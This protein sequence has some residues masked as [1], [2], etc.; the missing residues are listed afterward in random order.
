MTEQTERSCSRRGAAWDGWRSIASS[1]LALLLLL[2][3]GGSLPD[4]AAPAPNAA[5]PGSVDCIPLDA[6]P[7]GLFWDSK[8][9]AL[10]IADAAGNRILKWTEAG[11][12]VPF[13]ALPEAE[14]GAGLGQIAQSADGTL[15]VTRFGKGSTGG[16]IRI[17]PSGEAD[18]VP[19]LAPDR[20]RI[21][22]TV[23]AD[24]R[25]FDAWFRRGA[26]HER[27]GAV[28]E[29]DLAG[30]ETDVL[31]GL[32]KPIGVLAIGDALFVSDQEQGKILLAPLSEP[33]A[34]AL[35][36]NLEQPD[37]LAAGPDGAIFAGTRAGGVYRIERAGA[38][39]LA[40]P[41]QQ[42]IRGVAYDPDKRRL[43][44]SE[45]DADAKDGVH[46]ALC[47]ATALR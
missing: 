1:T 36:A 37:L 23:A 3:C 43:F 32:A 25:V 29:L 4:A 21:G 6:D 40:L 26:E 27:T 45:H 46:N 9:Q 22:L 24:G 31:T 38:V 14:A 8:N 47:I 16:V 7:N 2:G 12:V 39:S 10:L 41:S 5:Q 13:V 11:G 34:A 18:L 30:G 42:Q 35:L 28:S 15:L 20:R 17:S 19:E 44:A 33:R